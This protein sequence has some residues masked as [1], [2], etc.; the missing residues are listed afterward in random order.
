MYTQCIYN[1]LQM[2]NNPFLQVAILYYLNY[3]PFIR[4]IEIRSTQ[5]SGPEC[6]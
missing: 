4:L 1:A 6:Y 5:V 2:E 3:S